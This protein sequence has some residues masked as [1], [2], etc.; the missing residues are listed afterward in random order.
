M[1]VMIGFSFC[2]SIVVCIDEVDGSEMRFIECK[3][4]T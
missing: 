2:D 4:L 1:V 3:V